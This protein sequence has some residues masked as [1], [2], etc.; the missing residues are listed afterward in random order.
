MRNDSTD[1]IRLTE[2]F[3]ARDEEA[4]RETARLYEPL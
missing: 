4:L 2:L 1:T 3:F